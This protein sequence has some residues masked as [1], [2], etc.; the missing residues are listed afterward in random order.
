LVFRFEGQAYEGLTGLETALTQLDTVM[1]NMGKVDHLS[2]IEPPIDFHYVD[3]ERVNGL[4]SELTPEMEES[5]RKI[6]AHSSVTGK[7]GV[8]SGSISGEVGASKDATTESALRRTAYTPERKCIEIMR[9]ALSHERA[10]YYTNGGAWFIQRL[11]RDA[12]GK[13]VKA[14]SEPSPRE[15]TKEDLEKLRLPP[16]KEQEEESK[17]R[18]EAHSEEFQKEMESLA[19]LAIVDGQFSVKR[20]SQDSLVFSEEY[21]EKPLHI[22]FRAI[23]PGV[24]ELGKMLTIRSTRL[25]V[26]GTVVKPYGKDGIIELRPLAIF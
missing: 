2:D 22:V 11:L 21:S 24:A 14:T 26:F 19:G 12:Q 1:R 4:Y 16:T 9:F 20:I 6:S 13:Y 10:N 25:R 18:A 7:A 3:Q 5:E 8:S 15:I 23:A 17:R